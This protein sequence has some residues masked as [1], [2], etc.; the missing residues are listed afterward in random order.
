[1]VLFSLFLASPDIMLFV[2]IIWPFKPSM[3]ILSNTG[4]KT[5]SYDIWI[6]CLA[7]VTVSH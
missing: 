4:P 7:G 2:L 3:K 6:I 5:D 1:M